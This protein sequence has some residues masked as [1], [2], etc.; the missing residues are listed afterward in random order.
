M[1]LPD[2]KMK[3][4]E[5]STNDV[6]NG[7][8][9]LKRKRKKIVPVKSTGNKKDFIP[10]ESHTSTSSKRKIIKEN[11]PDISPSKKKGNDGVSS[12]LCGIS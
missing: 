1:K 5:S 9:V 11:S 8:W 3:T 10:S 12:Y 2:P 4:N 6:I 7:N